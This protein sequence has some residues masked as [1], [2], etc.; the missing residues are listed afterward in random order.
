MAHSTDSIIRRWAAEAG[1]DDP[2]F[3]NDNHTHIAQDRT[4]LYSYGTHFP[5]SVL[6]TG[7]S[8]TRDEDSW[9]L[10]NGDTYSHTTSQHQ[11]DTRGAIRAT[12]LPSMIVPF[13]AMRSAGIVMSSVKRVHVAAD[14]R[15]TV[16]HETGDWGKLP[17]HMRYVTQTSTEVRYRTEPCKN[18]PRGSLEPYYFEGGQLL[19]RNIGEDDCPGTDHFT[20]YT[21]YDYDQVRRSPDEDGIYRW[22]TTVHHLGASVFTATY[23][24]G[25]RPE[26]HWRTGH[27][28]E[29]MYKRFEDTGSYDWENPVTRRYYYTENTPV[30]AEAYFL[31]AFDEQES[32]PLYFLA[33]LPD[34]I[35][36]PRSVGEAF[37]ALKPEMVRRAEA[38]GK[39]ITRQGDV[40][41][42]E[43]GM[44]T[45][46]LS[47][48]GATAVITPP[49]EVSTADPE[50]YRRWRKQHNLGGTESWVLGVNHTASETMTAGDGHFTYARGTLRHRRVVHGVITRGEH[51][52]QR[53]GDGKTWHLLVKN[54][55][56]YVHGQSRAWTVG[57]GV[58]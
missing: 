26:R 38:D 48:L 27:D 20:P 28:R 52:R 23:Q 49:E 56:P 1:K 30:Y 8:G 4:T 13:S 10:V 39:A 35:S 57:G 42:V 25:T 19:R 34:G 3:L 6:M 50:R 9:F 29:A 16:Y 15:E 44:S 47:A 51:R 32:P 31:S 14:T 18:G 2:R 55:V 5:L 53:M 58:D 22:K 43:V 11:A 7:D 21:A 46:E 45:R 54:T 37:E 33:Q 41:A 17:R 36:E 40:F 24:A 12:G